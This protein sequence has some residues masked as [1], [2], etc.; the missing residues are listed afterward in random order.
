MGFSTMTSRSARS[1]VRQRD[2]VTQR[3]LPTRR[4]SQR[5]L[6]TWRAVERSRH[7]PHRPDHHPDDQERTTTRSVQP[8]ARNTTVAPRPSHE[9]KT[10]IKRQ[11]VVQGHACRLDEKPRPVPTP[12]TVHVKQ[13]LG[14]HTGLST[15]YRALQRVRCR[16]TLYGISRRRLRRHWRGWFALFP[17][18]PGEL[19]AMSDQV[20]GRG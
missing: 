1:S 8:G 10:M 7:R 6:H 13:Q 11:V 5:T 12:S 9:Q 4:A 3:P 18:L 19:R 16:I 17:R 2:R 14:P 15:C 20:I